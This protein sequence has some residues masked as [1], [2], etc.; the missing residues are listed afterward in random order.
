MAGWECSHMMCKI[1]RNYAHPQQLW[2][3]IGGGFGGSWW[4]M[5]AIGGMSLQ[6]QALKLNGRSFFLCIVF[7]S[8]R[9]LCAQYLRNILRDRLPQS[10]VVRKVARSLTNAG[11]GSLISA[12]YVPPS[13]FRWGGRVGVAFAAIVYSVQESSGIATLLIP[14]LWAPD[15]FETSYH[16]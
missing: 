16:S 7:E 15:T 9:S 1:L 13:H 2:I 6:T 11:S 12:F 14:P 4:Q 5:A 8:N 10:R 3:C